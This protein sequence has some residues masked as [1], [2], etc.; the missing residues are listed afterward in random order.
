MR[1]FYVFGLGQRKNSLIAYL[2]SSIRKNE[3]PKINNQRDCRIDWMQ[4]ENQIHN[5]IRAFS[6][7]PGAFTSYN[8]K[9]VKLFGSRIE[10]I[11]HEFNLKPGE[12]NYMKP[13][14]LIG[15]IDRSIL[16]KEIKLEGK[17]KV[18]ASD[19]ILGRT[20]IIGKYFE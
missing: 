10:H 18:P 11:P 14:L 20:K 17:M 12:I 6:P 15:T 3:I 19:F 7:S 5:Q 8:N 1:I 13:Y 16:I 4:P 2:I 9:R